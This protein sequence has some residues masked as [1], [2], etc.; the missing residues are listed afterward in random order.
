MAGSDRPLVT[1]RPT[2]L[3]EHH[4]AHLLRESSATRPAILLFLY[5]SKR[6]A[7]AAPSSSGW[8]HERELNDH[9]PVTFAFLSDH[10][11]QAL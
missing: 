2:G 3:L 4:C 10:G 8:G 9:N 11:S 6:R 1:V 7:F 5:K